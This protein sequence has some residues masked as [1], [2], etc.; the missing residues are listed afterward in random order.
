MNFL[1]IATDY[2]GTL[3]YQGMVP[4][5]TIKALEAARESGRKLI[6]VT[7]RALDELLRVFRRTDLFEWVV[8]ENGAL[9]GDAGVAAVGCLALGS[10]CW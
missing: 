10:R 1:G 8:A 7:G 5:S 3:A 9:S 4:E 6:L 2:D